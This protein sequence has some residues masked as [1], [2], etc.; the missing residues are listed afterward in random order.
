MCPRKETINL[1]FVEKLVGLRVYPTDARIN[2]GEITRTITK[3]SD[4]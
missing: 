4:R 3:I 1:N 2:T